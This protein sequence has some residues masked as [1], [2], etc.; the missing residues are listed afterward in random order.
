M[1]EWISKGQ[2]FASHCCPNQKS[3]YPNMIEAQNGALLS[4]VENVCSKGDCERYFFKKMEAE[5]YPQAKTIR[6]FGAAVVVMLLMKKGQADTTSAE[7]EICERCYRTLVN[8]VKINPQVSSRSKF[9]PA[10]YW[11]E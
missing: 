3:P 9:V 7:L 8:V 10:C 6:S 1:L 4:A 5:S 2:I 11:D